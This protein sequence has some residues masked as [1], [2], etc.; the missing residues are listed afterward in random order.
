[1]MKFFT[2]VDI[3]LSKHKPDYS[4]KIMFIGSCFAEN[5]AIKMQNAGFNVDINP[6][7]I[8]YNPLSVVTCIEE[9]LNDNKY[10]AEDIFEYKGMYHSFSHHSRFSAPDIEACIS[11]INTRMTYS[12][13]FLQQADF[14]FITFGTSNV[15]R[16]KETGRIVSNCHKLP[17]RMFDFQTLELSEIT[18]KWEEILSRLHEKNPDLKIV[19]TVSPIRHWKDGAHENQLSKAKL[20]LGVDHLVKCFSNCSYFPSYEIMMDEL[21]DYRYY[22]E[23]MLHPSDIAVNYIWEKF[24]GAFLDRSTLA[25]MKEWTGIQQAIN[26]K[27]F[28]PDS[29]EY[30]RFKIQTQK[31]LGDYK[32]KYSI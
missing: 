25:R 32:K 23:D 31:R 11:Q 1:M 3:P 8:V 5:M 17:A 29:E 28:Y 16:W 13:E 4:G 26:H 19:F 12:S 9:L 18:E 10:E 14:L 24:T 6:F 15:Y 7:G 30:E 27:P 2:E 22:A 20:L 21:R